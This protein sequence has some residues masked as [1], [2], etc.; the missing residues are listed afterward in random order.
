MSGIFK[1]SPGIVILPIIFLACIQEIELDLGEDPVLVID[2]TLTNQE[3]PHIITLSYSTGFNKNPIFVPIK[4][5]LLNARVSIE[6]Q[7]G[8]E[9]LLTEIPNTG[10][11]ATSTGYQGVVGSTYKLLVTLSNGKQYQSRSEKINPV[12]AIDEVTFKVENRN[13]L[14][15]NSIS[16]KKYV[17]LFI[18]FKDEIETDNYYRW[19]YE[20]T[21]EVLAPLV[22]ELCVPT[23]SP[24]PS[25]N[26][27]P[28]LIPCPVDLRNCWATDYDSE[29]LRISDDVLF[30]GKHV[31]EFE[32]YAA[33]SSR[34]FNIGYNALIKQFSLTKD[35]YNYYKSIKDQLGN[36][37]SIFETPN[38]QIKGNIQS[39]ET[40]GEPV[41]GYFSASAVE[42][43][44][45]HLRSTD[46]T[47][48]LGEIDCTQNSDGSFP[49]ACLD[50]TKWPATNIKPDFW[51]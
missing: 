47:S 32:I 50:C 1:F 42:T 24:E 27:E 48:G 5:E 26:D 36:T 34:K 16:I 13:I 43:K 11:Y 3:G 2:G 9:E 14:S 46:Y 45:L 25:P 38:Y 15:N 21:Y 51:P 29:F 7:S 39:L 30:N 35:A 33:E 28:V 40:P 31:K 6:D 44:R 37:G 8:N 23:P 20:E 17:V 12:P 18:D 10:K 19:R 49:P 22:P 41:L 4:S